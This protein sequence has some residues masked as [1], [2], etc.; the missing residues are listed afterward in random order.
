LL[1]V[2]QQ[3]RH[4][5]DSI[6]ADY[7]VPVGLQLDL[8]RIGFHTFR[9]TYR[10]WLDEMGAPVAG[11][12]SLKAVNEQKRAANAQVVGQLMSTAVAVSA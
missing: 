1:P 3:D 4:R 10:A 2:S 8:G 7:P 12:N 9:H 6:R 11:R 5:P